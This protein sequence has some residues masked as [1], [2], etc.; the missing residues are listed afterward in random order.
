MLTLADS[1]RERIEELEHHVRSTTHQL[2]QNTDQLTQMEILLSAERNERARLESGS[3]LTRKDS[4]LDPNEDV[5]RE[6]SKVKERCLV[7]EKELRLKE[8]LIL[9]QKERAMRFEEMTMKYTKDLKVHENKIE[10]IELRASQET[11]F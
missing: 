2:T 3:N 5:R 4:N 9:E 10:E 1:A 7:L 11:S 6:Y 8:S